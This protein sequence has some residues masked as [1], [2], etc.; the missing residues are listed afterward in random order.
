VAPSIAHPARGADGGR[1][2]RLIPCV[3]FRA[4]APALCVATGCS[5]MVPGPRTRLAPDEKRS[6][7]TSLAVA[8]VDTVVAAAAIGAAPYFFSKAKES[9]CGS[10]AE[11][12][13]P[14]QGLGYGLAGITM[15][16]LALFEVMAAT[17][18]YGSYAECR[19]LE[20]DPL[21]LP[22]ED[23]GGLVEWLNAKL[24]AEDPPIR[25]AAG[26][27]DGETLVVTTVG[28]ATSGAL[29][30]VLMRHDLTRPIGAHFTRVVCNPEL[31]PER[32]SP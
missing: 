12:E 28:C 1:L 16:P 21:A 29:S 31:I 8:V 30:R 27:A 2:M 24:A 17:H 5:F 14:G 26:G 7:G 11:C 22:P 20:A 18:G 6:C 13:A 25:V 15:I 3:A 9:S 19:A 4:L 23:R 10:N 32:P